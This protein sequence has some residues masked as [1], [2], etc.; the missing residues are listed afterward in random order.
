M[1]RLASIPAI[2]LLA[3]ML[4]APSVWAATEWKIH[5]T[6]KLEHPPIDMLISYNKAWIYVLDD[7]GWVS[8]YNAEGQLKDKIQV[9]ADVRQIKAGPSDNVLFLLNRKAGTIQV[10]SI[11]FVEDIDIG[12]SPVKGRPDAPVSIVVFSDFQ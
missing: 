5:Q 3:I 10:I 4:S 2:I 12:G 9:G 6:V 1:K 7:H 11:A 8:I